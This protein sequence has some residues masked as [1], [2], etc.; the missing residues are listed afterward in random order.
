MVVDARPA[1]FK[2][3]CGALLRR[4]GW[5]RFPSIPA[6]FRADDSQDDSHSSGRPRTAT[7]ASGR[8]RLFAIC[9]GKLAPDGR[10][11][12]QSAFLARA[13]DSRPSTVSMVGGRARWTISILV[14]GAVLFLVG[15]LVYLG[16]IRWSPGTAVIAIGLAIF[17][18]LGARGRQGMR[19]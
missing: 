10:Q 15:G 9:G 2:T 12:G 19:K 14:T 8:A 4:P 7:D 1:V 13:V 18:I 11:L 17:G 16:G 3:V 6:S 5:V